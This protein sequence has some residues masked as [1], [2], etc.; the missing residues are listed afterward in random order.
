MSI[1]KVTLRPTDRLW[2]LYLRRMYNYTCQWCGRV[3]T[4]ENCGNLGTSHY[5]GRGHENTRFDIE[6]TF[7]MCNIPCHCYLD[8][9]GRAEYTEWL[10]NR[11][12]QEKFDLLTLRANIYKKRDDVSDKMV[13]KKMLE[14]Q[15]QFMEV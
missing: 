7:P 13:I 14:E 3:Y 15:A 8:R 11:I 2:T 1:Y 12:G 10:I 9:E 4:Q 5:F 6:N